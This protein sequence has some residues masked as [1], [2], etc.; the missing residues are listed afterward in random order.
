M[1]RSLLAFTATLGAVAVAGLAYAGWGLGQAFADSDGE[2]PQ[3]VVATWMRD[4]Q[5]GWAV[6][7]LEDV[8]YA[9]V[10]RARV[11]GSP[12]ISADL[13]ADLA[14]D[15]DAGPSATPA[16]TPIAG[17]TPTST[18]VAGA[19]PTSTPI[20]GATPTSTPSQ[21]QSPSPSP[22][23]THLDPPPP[24]ISPVAEPEPMEGIWQPVGGK[25][26]GLPAMYATRV[27]ADDVH[28]SYYASVLWIDPT[29]ATTMFVPGYE[30][31]L[32]G[33]NP[34]DGALPEEYW[35]GLLANVNGGFR[36]NDSQGGYAYDGQ[37][38][39]P[40]A[41]G[42]ASA[43]VYRDGRL[44]I[45][46]W[47]RDFA[48]LTDDMMAV[49]QNLA[50]IVDKGVSRVSNPNDTYVWGGTTDKESMAWRSAIGQRADG[51]ILYVGSPFLSAAGLA[52]TMVRAGAQRAMVLDMNDWWTAGFIFRHRRNGELVCRKLDPSIIGDCER[53][54]HRYKRD[55]FHFLARAAPD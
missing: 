23:R 39:R 7:R 33:P 25:V 44:E 32:G 11:G 5:L 20:A 21:S 1:R 24:I 27:R 17:A 52:D 50:L 4:H 3:V 18:P 31:P 14:G 10:A 9:T 35:P 55:S 13:G 6:A 36:L 12:S 53:F 8:Y 42:I 19:T 2:P 26:D 47:G 45:G 38:V 41:K 28:T 48:G 49:R 15:P 16:P 29:L 22:S 54:L 43:V 37:V 30:E 40:L 46:R 34:F 51:S